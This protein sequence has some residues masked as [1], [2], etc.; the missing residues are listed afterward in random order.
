MT[1]RTGKARPNEDP[2]ILQGSFSQD[3]YLPSTANL[4]QN[5]EETA[6]YTRWVGT[7]LGAY[8]YML[9]SAS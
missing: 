1:D 4:P 7:G 6:P 9:L 2:K 8:V 5:G 3:L